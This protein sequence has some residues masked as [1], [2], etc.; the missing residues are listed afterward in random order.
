MNAGLQDVV[1]SLD[2]E[3]SKVWVCD[4][5]IGNVGGVQNL[6]V[7]RSEPDLVFSSGCEP[8]RSLCADESNAWLDL[9]GAF[10]GDVGLYQLKDPKV[11]AQDLEIRG[12][13]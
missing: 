3:L 6:I 5:L 12:T 10:I 4:T 2:P 9:K 7:S 13:A 1:K 11:R 8:W